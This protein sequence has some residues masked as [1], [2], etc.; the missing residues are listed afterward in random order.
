MEGKHAED[1]W[2]LIN[3]LSGK[4]MY[5]RE[6]TNETSFASSIDIS[7]YVNGMYTITVSNK[8]GL[9]TETFMKL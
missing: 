8:D 1:Y 5:K 6:L 7:S 3:D 4:L 2:I 9:R